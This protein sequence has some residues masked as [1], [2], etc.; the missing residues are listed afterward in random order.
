MFLRLSAIAVFIVAVG[1]LLAGAILMRPVTVHASDFA[2]RFIT[3]KAQQA[4]PLFQFDDEKGSA[5]DL[6][7]YRGRYVLLNLWATWCGPCVKEMPSLNT[8]Q[9]QFDPHQL[10]VLAVNEDRNGS[11]AAE[12]FYTRHNLKALPIF[13]D[14]SGQ[15]PFLLHTPGLPLTVLIDPQ[16]VEI[17]RVEGEEDW[18]APDSIAYLKSQ[19]KL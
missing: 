10:V 9:R 16:G 12:A 5:H 3:T 13:I 18:S 7:D 19:M 14:T 17:G 8:L 2:G 6:K 11:V 15:A 4:V 1:C